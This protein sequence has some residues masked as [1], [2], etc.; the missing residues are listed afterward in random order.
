MKNSKSLIFSGALVAGAVISL[1][2]TEISTSQ[3]KGFSDL[4]TG[5][6]VRTNIL[7]DKEDFKVNVFEMKCAA[8]ETQQKSEKKTEKGT[9][10][11]EKA[12]EHKCGEGKCGEGKCAANAKTMKQTTGKTEKD[13][14]AAKD[15]SKMKESKSQ[16]M[17]CGEGK[18]G[19]Q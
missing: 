12:V 6:D 16:E 18:C 11:N 4:G 15:T 5:S 10:K 3:T 8:T 7:F 1:S 19:V 14:K 17:K 2:A 9:L 13:M